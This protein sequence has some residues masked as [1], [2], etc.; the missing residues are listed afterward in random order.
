MVF[1]TPLH[2]NNQ[3][4]FPLIGDFSL[5]GFAID[6]QVVNFAINLSQRMTVKFSCNFLL[7]HNFPIPFLFGNFFRRCLARLSATNKIA[8][9][10]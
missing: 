6:A 10:G 7:S 4:V 8:N 5:F 1:T 2:F 3:K 9:A